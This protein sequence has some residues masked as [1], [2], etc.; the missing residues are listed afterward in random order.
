MLQT[1]SLMCDSNEII[2]W[3]CIAIVSKKLDV[4]AAALVTLYRPISPGEKL[5]CDEGFWKL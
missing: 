3:I 1:E 2:S 4:V 5:V